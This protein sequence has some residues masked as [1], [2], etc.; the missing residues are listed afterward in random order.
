M[1]DH[2]NY[3]LDW[4]YLY[5]QKNTEEL[6]QTLWSTTMELEA[7]KIKVIR[8]ERVFTAAPPAQPYSNISSIEDEPI[9]NH[10][11]SSSDCEESI[12]SSPPAPE[13]FE[14]PAKGLPENGKFLEAVMKAGPLLNN[15]LLAGQ[16]PHW[17]HPPPPLD[18]HQIP[19][20]VPPPPV[21]YA[22][23]CSEFSKKR[24]FHE[25]CDSSSETKY[26]RIS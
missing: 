11:F 5:K 8:K 13:N 19:L 17:R 10:G 14:I 2:P 23:N 7:T 1:E 12:V 25:D 20:V 16:L 9:T 6:T 4:S 26:Q 3:I 22:L 15:L 18:C 21:S 24:V